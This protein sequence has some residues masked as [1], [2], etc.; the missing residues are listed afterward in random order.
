MFK[1]D[2]L[3]DRLDNFRELKQSELFYFLSTVAKIRLN[4]D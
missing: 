2:I 3:M 4:P 1:F